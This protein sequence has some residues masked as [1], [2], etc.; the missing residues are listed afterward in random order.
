[1]E[2]DF[3]T[4]SHNKDSEATNQVIRRMAMEYENVIGVVDNDDGT[5]WDGEIQDIYHPFDNYIHFGKIGNMYL[6]RHWLSAIETIIHKEMSRYEHI[7]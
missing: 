6:A 3:H 4:G 5:L 2:T 7:Y 1:M